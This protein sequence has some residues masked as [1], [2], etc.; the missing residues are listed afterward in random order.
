M[1]ALRKTR[2]RY[3]SGIRYKERLRSSAFKRDVGGLQHGAPVAEPPKPGWR[4]ESRKKTRRK[5]ALKTKMEYAS[6]R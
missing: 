2:E 1:G 5:Q 6:R 4:S 3:L